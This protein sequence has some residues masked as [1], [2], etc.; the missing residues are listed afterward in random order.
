MSKQ[1]AVLQHE[2]FAGSSFSDVI[3]KVLEFEKEKEINFC[4]LRCDVLD[5]EFIA[6]LK[7]TANKYYF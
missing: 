4:E 6:T 1:K 7:Y 2:T 3:T 5:G